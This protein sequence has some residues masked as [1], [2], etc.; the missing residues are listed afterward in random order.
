MIQA[1][2]KFMQDKETVTSQELYNQFKGRYYHNAG[3]YIGEAM[4]R[5]VK[6][7]KVIC[8]SK[9]VFSLPNSKDMNIDDNLPNL[10]N[11]I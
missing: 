1:I 2:L 5:A 6:S 10:F 3:K 7:G 11:Q 9:G 4:S 8:V